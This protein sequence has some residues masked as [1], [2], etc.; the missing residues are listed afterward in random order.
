MGHVDSVQE[1]AR[2]ARKSS[3]CFA[4]EFGHECFFSGSACDTYNKHGESDKCTDGTGNAFV[5]DVYEFVSG[6]SLIPRHLWV[7]D[8]W[9]MKIFGKIISLKKMFFLKKA[10]CRKF[11]K[12]HLTIVSF[13]CHCRSVRLPS[14][15]NSLFSF[16]YPGTH[17]L[18]IWYYPCSSFGLAVLGITYNKKGEKL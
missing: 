6:N 11:G 15:S 14:S 8:Y 4:I 13:F 1:C 12:S 9:V 7:V 17:R 5:L 2:F 10:K 3:L 16:Q 18:Y